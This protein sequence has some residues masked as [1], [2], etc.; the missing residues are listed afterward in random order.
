MT[1]ITKTH[2]CAKAYKKEFLK[3]G[4]VTNLQKIYSEDLPNGAEELR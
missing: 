2:V 3:T 1:K 4:Y